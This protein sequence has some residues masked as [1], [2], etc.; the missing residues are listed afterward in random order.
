MVSRSKYRPRIWDAYSDHVKAGKSAMTIFYRID[1]AFS[2]RNSAKK[3]YKKL[4]DARKCGTT[5]ALLYLASN[6]R[7]INNT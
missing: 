5:T 7:Q 3:N 1:L 6:F 4:R 2:N